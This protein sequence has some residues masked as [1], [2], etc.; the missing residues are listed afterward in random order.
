M[1]SIPVERPP[2]GGRRGSGSA[3][4]LVE[5]RGV[6]VTV[7]AVNWAEVDSVIDPRSGTI[8]RKTAL[9]PIVGIKQ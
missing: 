5:D 6:R 3:V 8:L 4:L 7:A 2:G 9:T 1:V